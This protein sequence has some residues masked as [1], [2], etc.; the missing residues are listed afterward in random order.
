MRE[1]TAAMGRFDGELN[2]WTYPGLDEKVAW[3]KQYW[4]EH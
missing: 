1:Q 2:D 3:W 4:R